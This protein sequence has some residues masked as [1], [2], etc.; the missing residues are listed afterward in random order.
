[1]YAETPSTATV[2]SATATVELEE[3]IVIAARE[4]TDAEAA[5]GC[6]RIQSPRLSEYFGAQAPN[7]SSGR[8]SGWRGGLLLG[9]SPSP[10]ER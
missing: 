8:C 2:D 3:V 4:C 1:M 7:L 10:P 6:A 9:L 5:T